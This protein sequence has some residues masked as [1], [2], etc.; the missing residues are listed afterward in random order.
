MLCP[1]VLSCSTYLVVRAHALG[2]GGS[3]ATTLH[4]HHDYG[5]AAQERRSVHG[6]PSGKRGFASEG[7]AISY[8]LN[9]RTKPRI[10]VQLCPGAPRLAQ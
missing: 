10:Q 6:C 9:I 3:G 8:I 4:D 2:S 1:R 7:K 5:D